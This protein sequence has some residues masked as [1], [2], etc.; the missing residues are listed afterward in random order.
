MK[1]WLE[2]EPKNLAG[3]RTRKYVGSGRKLVQHLSVRRRAEA[4]VPVQ[5]NWLE[6]EK[7]AQEI[8]WLEAAREGV[9]SGSTSRK[10]LEQKGLERTHTFTCALLSFITPVVVARGGRER[11]NPA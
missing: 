4:A 8:N 10:S 7:K 9:K 11:S 5:E 1:L 3:S 6:T 2:T